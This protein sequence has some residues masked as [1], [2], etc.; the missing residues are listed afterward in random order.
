[1]THVVPGFVNS[2]SS[3]RTCINMVAWLCVRCSPHNTAASPQMYAFPGPLA[4]D[5]AAVHQQLLNFLHGGYQ[6]VEGHAVPGEPSALS[7]VTDALQQL[8]A[9]AEQWG[10]AV[11]AVAGV[12][13]FL[14]S[15][16]VENG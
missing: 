8:R 16:A 14:V 3:I 1:M 5:A 6:E 4:T 11:T 15:I 7:S 12:L 9:Q 2:A 10:G 13:I